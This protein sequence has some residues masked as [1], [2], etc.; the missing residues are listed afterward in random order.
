MIKYIFTLFLIASSCHAFPYTWS[1]YDDKTKTLTF[2]ERFSGSC[3]AS[4]DRH[5][6]L[7]YKP[8]TTAIDQKNDIAYFLVNNRDFKDSFLRPTGKL[9]VYDLS[10]GA[11]I[12]IFLINNV[13]GS[14]DIYK[15]YIQAAGQYFR[16]YASK[17]SIRSDLFN[18]SLWYLFTEYAFANDEFSFLPLLG[19]DLDSNAV[20]GTI[21]ANDDEA[22]IADALYHYREDMDPKAANALFYKALQAGNPYARAIMHLAFKHGLWCMPQVETLAEHYREGADQKSITEA[23]QNLLPLKSYVLLGVG[24]IK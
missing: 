24:F 3:G 8:E 6:S 14:I 20:L 4:P 10:V 19:A 5:I 21:F 15:E 12:H 18:G 11:T 2:G 22:I 17:R 9:Y 23:E 7:S 1:Q 13:R 16:R